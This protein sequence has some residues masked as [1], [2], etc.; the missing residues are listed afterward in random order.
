MTD[1]QKTAQ[2]EW[3][4]PFESM[5]FESMPFAEMMQK[6]MGRQWQGC[7]WTKMMSQMMAMC[8]EARGETEEEADPEVAQKA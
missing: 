6:M 4:V 3:R 2:E 1:K 8:G 7:D 5:P